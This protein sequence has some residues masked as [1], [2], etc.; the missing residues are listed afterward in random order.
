MPARGSLVDR[1]GGW[2]VGA[3]LLRWPAV[4]W[5]AV[6][7]LASGLA[8]RSL[9]G[10]DGV[11]PGI[12]AADVTLL[13]DPAPRFDGVRVDVRWGHRR[14][15]A[16]A[17]GVSADA[18]R[19]RLAGE[20]VTVRGTVRPVEPDQPWLRRSS[21][22]RRAHGAP[23]RRL[24]TG[25]PAQP[26]RQ[27]ACAAPSSPAP[28]RCD[29]RARSLYTGLV[30]GDDREQ[31]ADLADSF[32][33]AGPHPPARRVGPERGV[34]A[35]AR[36]AAAP[37]PAPLA[38]PRRHPRGDRAL[39]ADDALR[40]VG[41]PRV[42]DGRAGGHPRDAGPA[43]LPPARRR[44]RGHRRSCWSIRCSCARPASSC[45]PARPIAIVVLAPRLAVGAPR[46]R[47]RSARPRA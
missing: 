47:R 34:R 22:R 27:R 6:A 9:D 15:E 25:R 7:L 5:I 44:S 46:P 26:G 18:L 35:G 11:E 24:A 19:A 13:S 45:R 4:R 40:A 30:I 10:L 29:P 28:R 21:H 36:R 3:A 43:D 8:Q 2:R 12:V 37:P 1:A 14:L 33:G 39:R 38:A 16:R 32:R 31:P 23:R 20:V 41:A 17:R 42:G